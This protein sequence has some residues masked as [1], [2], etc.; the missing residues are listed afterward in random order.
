MRAH[1]TK[2]ENPSWGKNCF[3]GSSTSP[4]MRG[5]TASLGA[6]IASCALAVS[7]SAAPPVILKTSFS[8]VS[9]ETAILKAE[10]NPGE[11]KTKYRFEYGLADCA[12][13]TCTK[14]PL[15]EGEIEKGNAPVLVK[16]KVGGLTPSTTYHFRVVAKNANGEVPSPDRTFLTAPVPSPFGPCPNDQVRKGNPMAP[17]IEYSSAN[18]PDCRAYEQASPVEKSGNDAKGMVLSVKASLSGD[19]ISFVTI[20]GIPGGEG[21]QDIP[22]WLARKGQGGW[23][24]QGLLPPASAG[25]QAF[26]RS[27]SPDFTQVFDWARRLG[28]PKEEAFLAI[29]TLDRSQTEVVPYLSGGGDTA[30]DLAG[31]NPDGSAIAFES[32]SKLLPAAIA[33]KS[34]V[35]AWKRSGGVL[36][37]ASVLNDGTSPN[38]EGSFAGSYDWSGAPTPALPGSSRLEFGGAALGQYTQDQGAVSADGKDVFFTTTPGGQLYVRLNATEEQSPLDPQG[39]CTDKA[40]ACTLQLSASRRTVPDPAGTRPAAFMAASA[41]GS[42]AYFT[43]PEKLTDDAK[44]GPEIEPPT[45]ARSGPRRRPQGGFAF[46]PQKAKGLVASGGFLY[47]A[48]P[49]EDAIGRAKLNGAGAATE[50]EQNVHPRRRRTGAS[51][52]AVGGRRCRT[53]LLDQLAH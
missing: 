51:Q 39:K 12:V 49:E 28:P 30:T 6:L 33:G 10:I 16:V 26:V 4:I 8:N 32:Q 29:S 21:A 34:N 41:D 23:A 40:K 14:V 18:L 15:P 43:S 9:H 25:Q 13:K 35:Y 3:L 17:L 11:L 20:S 31:S 53:P 52:P 36:R 42:T 46:L 5:L 37:L 50:V 1:T 44:T 2:L 38:A 45:I 19:A 24:T 47:W 48:S 22:T 7:A 27:W